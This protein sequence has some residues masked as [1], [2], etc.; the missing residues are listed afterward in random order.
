MGRIL[1]HD[2]MKCLL[3]GFLICTIVSLQWLQL[4]YSPVAVREWNILQNLLMVLTNLGWISLLNLVLVLI[5]QKWEVSLSIVSVGIGLWSIVGYYVTVFHGSP[6]CFTMLRNAGTAM[7]VAGSYTYA[8]DGHVVVLLALSAVQIG[9]L[10]MLGRIKTRPGFS[11]KRFAF[12]ASVLAANCLV[13]YIA[14]FDGTPVKPEK[15]IGWRW[16]EPMN[17]Y[18]YTCCL[19][20]DLG[21]LVN[22]YSEPEGYDSKAIHWEASEESAP[23]ALPDVILI[24]NETFFDLTR[25]S[26]VQPDRDIFAGFYGL[27]NAVTGHAV[28]PMA[29]GGTNNAEFELL[30][31]NSM[32][33]LN[34]DAPFHYVDFAPENSN[35]VRYFEDLG[36][37]TWGMHCEVASNYARN[38]VYPQL[39]FDHVLLGKDAFHY[40][41]TCG[42]RR[43]LDSDNYRDLLDQYEAADNAPRFLYLLTY[44][45]HGGFTQN[46]PTLDTVHAANVPEELADQVDEYLTSVDLSVQAFLDLTEYFETVDRP[47]IICM[48][49]D[50]GP[51]FIEQLGPKAELSSEEASVVARATPYVIWANFPLDVTSG[52]DASMVDLVP[53]MLR[54]AGLPLTPYYESILALHEELPVRTSDGITVDR[55]GT[56]AAYT[57]GRPEFEK[58]TQYYY[59]EFNGLKAGSD[60]IAELFS[61]PKD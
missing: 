48:V 32:Y 3:R 56:V 54:Q 23:E 58:L 49:G 6:L 24:L 51:S 41:N 9:L 13:L 25:Y 53:M 60:L 42:N 47:V 14:L 17:I 43:W 12:R 21:N 35:V 57:Y 46:D 16:S 30:T 44:Q 5:L 20:E 19:V 52:G 39:G 29:G 40:V 7:N 59:M 2:G 27:D 36:Y 31:S 15:S 45:N 11:W 37:T 22:P 61:V 10:I 18:G 8:I 28:T 50:H 26:D 4:E 38:R 55:D 34:A 33:L 1:K